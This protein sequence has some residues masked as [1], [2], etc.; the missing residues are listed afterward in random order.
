M[1]GVSIINEKSK[2]IDL[3][4]ETIIPIQSNLSR[5][6]TQ[7]TKNVWPYKTDGS[8]GQIVLIGNVLQRDNNRVAA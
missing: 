6:V 2:G 1:M 3:L 5:A 7:G 8:L 4:R